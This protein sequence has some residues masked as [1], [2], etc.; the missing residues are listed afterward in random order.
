MKYQ[1]KQ[2]PVDAVQ[3]QGSNFTEV[4]D[5]ARVFPHCRQDNPKVPFLISCNAGR[6][7]LNPGDWLVKDT[8]GTVGAYTDAEFHR[9]HKK[10]RYQPG[11]DTE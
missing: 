1:T 8:Y 4:Y 10:A 5:F 6:A 9:L 7:E 11:E 3:F 2:Q